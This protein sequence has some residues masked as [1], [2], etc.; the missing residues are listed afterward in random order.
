MHLVCSPHIIRRRHFAVVRLRTVGALAASC[1]RGWPRRTSGL[2]AACEN[3]VISTA[4]AGAGASM[5][6]QPGSRS[7]APTE[8]RRP[9]AR[10]RPGLP[11]GGG[12]LFWEARVRTKINWRIESPL[13]AGAS[14]D[15]LVHVTNA[16]RVIA[17]V[18]QQC[19]R[20]RLED[21]SYGVQ[22]A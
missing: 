7:L 5:L 1:F 19:C 16:E 2:G 20:Q 12:G 10:Q 3:A 14:R 15:A 13:T 8:Q 6:N 11:G 4:S 18:N 22:G 17:A 9:P 21:S